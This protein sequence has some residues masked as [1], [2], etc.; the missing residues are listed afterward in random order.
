MM[1][2]ELA[3]PDS[4]GDLDQ[5]DDETE[6]GD[7]SEQMKNI[8]DDEDDEHK[9]TDNAGEER[10][11]LL[12]EEQKEKSSPSIQLAAAGSGETHHTHANSGIK[13]DIEQG[14]SPRESQ[15]S[16]GG[17][18]ADGGCRSVCGPSPLRVSVICIILISF[19]I[20]LVFIMHLDK[21]VT[22]VQISLENTEGLLDTMEDSAAAYRRSSFK[23]MKSLHE[24]IGHL[25]NLLHSQGNRN[26]AK[27]PECI[28]STPASSATNEEPFASGWE[29][30]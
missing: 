8:D 15:Y 19:W 27:S 9:E 20:L 1:M 7:K 14:P 3:K 6:E 11:S 23:K 30:W 29:D 13:V 2:A 12:T 4:M 18:E 16:G 25:I 22:N 28:T 17:R 24:K 26:V 10:T 5:D 21:K